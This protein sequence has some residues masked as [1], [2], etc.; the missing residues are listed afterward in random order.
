MLTGIGRPA[1]PTSAVD[2]LLECH[3]RIRTFL[4][5][6]RRLGEAETPDPAEAADAARQVI[7]YFTQALPLH[8]RD[9]ED[10]IAPRLRGRDA[11]LDAAL[12]AMARE[13]EEHQRPVEELIGACSALVL[14][15][16]RH[17]ALAPAIA[18]AA[19]ELERHFALH[20]AREEE[21][22]FPALR[23]HLDPAADAALAGEIRR[24]RQGT[25]GSAP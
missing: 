13:H 16:G 3:G 12:A 5:L 4:A 11:G 17:A 9:E 15:P 1:A 14:D 2:L 18:Q 20:L 7:R 19:A 24:R 8:A 21:E 22:V 25:G 6:A 10:S 23:R